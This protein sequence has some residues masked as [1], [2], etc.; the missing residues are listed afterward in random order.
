MAAMIDPREQTFPIFIN[1]KALA[2][3]DILRSVYFA[4]LPH[5]QTLRD[6]C[7]V[8]T[9]F[10]FTDPRP[11]GNQRRVCI[12]HA[13]KNEVRMHWAKLLPDRLILDIPELSEFCYEM[14]VLSANKLKRERRMLNFTFGNGVDAPHRVISPQHTNNQ[15]I[16]GCF[17]SNWKQPDL[18]SPVKWANQSILSVHPLDAMRSWPGPIVFFSFGYPTPPF[19][20]TTCSIADFTETDFVHTVLY[21]QHLNFSGT[22]PPLCCGASPPTSQKRDIAPPNLDPELYFLT[23]ANTAG[24]QAKA[25]AATS[26][27][28]DAKQLKKIMLQLSHGCVME[29]SRR[30][31]VDLRGKWFKSR[32]SLRDH[33][34]KGKHGLVP[35]LQCPDVPGRAMKPRLQKCAAA[36]RQG[37]EFAGVKNCEV[38]E[39]KLLP[40]IKENS[41][42]EPKEEDNT[43]MSNDEMDAPGL[44]FENNAGR[45]ERALDTSGSDSEGDVANSG[46]VPEFSLDFGNLGTI[47]AVNSGP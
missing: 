37:P 12:F 25:Q 27:V 47:L 31:G 43:A 2:R 38:P 22:P 23:A 42:M 29:R 24:I 28:N 15:G 3:R 36:F 17:A 5:P 7:E 11:S 45:L 1:W 33:W 19:L 18:P 8:V 26:P 20:D 13:Q 44:D 46:A 4:R 14:N 21:L 41:E 16:A 6:A 34:C 39:G 40:V 32:G 30:N 10:G 9:P 35:C